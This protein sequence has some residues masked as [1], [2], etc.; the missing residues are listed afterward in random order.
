[1][2]RRPESIRRPVPMAFQLLA[3]GIRSASISKRS[4]SPTVQ[5]GVISDAMKNF[6]IEACVARNIY[7]QKFNCYIAS[8]PP[9]NPC[10]LHRNACALASFPAYCKQQEAGRGLGMRLHVHHT[11]NRGCQYYWLMSTYLYH[12]PLKRPPYGG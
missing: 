3:T 8:L 10:H 2:S 6:F 12:S 11:C 1:M 7:I 4:S 9:A 5:E